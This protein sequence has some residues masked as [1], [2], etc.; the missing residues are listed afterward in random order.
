MLC[1]NNNVLRVDARSLQ[2]Q[3]NIAIP[4][5]QVK[6]V[7]S[8]AAFTMQNKNTLCSIVTICTGDYGCYGVGGSTVVR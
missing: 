2:N 4:P 1:H 8:R 5:Y 3:T 7:L 6:A